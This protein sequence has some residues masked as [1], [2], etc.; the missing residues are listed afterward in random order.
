MLKKDPGEIIRLIINI[1]AF[2]IFLVFGIQQINASSDLAGKTMLFILIF[3][4][5][6]FAIWYEMVRYVHRQAIF[7]LN[8]ECDPDKARSIMEKCKKLDFFNG[9]KNPNVVFDLLYL[10]DKQESEALINLINKHEKSL[11][12][13]SRSEERRVG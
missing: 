4:F 10:T 5:L 6:F 1:I 11:L 9:Y 13:R 12:K 3:T 2:V 8:F 7:A